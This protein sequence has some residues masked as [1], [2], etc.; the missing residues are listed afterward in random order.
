MGSQSDDM[1]AQAKRAE[2]LSHTVSD[3]DAC[4]KLKALAQQFEADA[5]RIDCPPDRTD[6][7]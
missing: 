5:D 1:R 4:Q 3:D 2:R 6:R 7:S